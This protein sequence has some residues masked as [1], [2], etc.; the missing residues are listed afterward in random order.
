MLRAPQRTTIAEGFL[1][2]AGNLGIDATTLFPPFPPVQRNSDGIAGRL[3]QWCFPAS[4]RGYLN[5]AVLHDPVAA[6][7]QS[8]DAWFE[9]V[10]RIRFAD[11]LTVFF[12]DLDAEGPGEEPRE[13]LRALGARFSRL[14]R[15]STAGYAEALRERLF[16]REAARVAQ[17][18]KLAREDL[19]QFFAALHERYVQ[20]MREAVG[21][22][23]FLLPRDI[24]NA[25]LE[26][27][28]QITGRLGALLEAWPRLWDAM[29]AMKERG[30]RLSRAL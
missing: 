6:R 2:M 28:Q 27:T 17:S 12:P 18:R 13:A 21:R 30:R 24:P 22:D 7:S 8:V 1:T 20:V 25:S 3:L 26:M 14:G 4:C 11:A 16:G 15:L 10:Q 29:T 9:E 19:P 23:E 5:W